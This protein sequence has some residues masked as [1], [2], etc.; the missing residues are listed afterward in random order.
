MYE[1]IICKII[2]TKLSTSFK[3][4]TKN[5]GNLSLKNFKSSFSPSFVRDASETILPKSNYVCAT[6][7]IRL[8]IWSP[9]FYSPLR[10]DYKNNKGFVWKMQFNSS[11]ANVGLNR[12]WKVGHT[13]MSFCFR[14]G[15]FKECSSPP[16]GFGWVIC[17]RK[18]GG[19]PRLGKGDMASGTPPSSYYLLGQSHNS[20]TFCFVF[21]FTAFHSH[22][23]ILFVHLFLISS[24]SSFIKGWVIA[25]NWFTISRTYSFCNYFSVIKSYVCTYINLIY[26]HRY[27]H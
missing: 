27:D 6:A 13:L 18:Y 21:L 26:M 15:V 24:N 8:V 25:R 14:F 12:G 11:Y 17:Q 10:Y 5:P 22:W 23:P 19:K 3:F 4:C 20:N 2:S 7:V 1:I 9:D 16:S